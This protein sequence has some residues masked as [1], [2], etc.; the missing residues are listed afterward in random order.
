[1]KNFASALENVMPDAAAS[2]NGWTGSRASPA[3]ALL[4]HLQLC[5]ALLGRRGAFAAFFCAPLT[6][7]RKSPDAIASG[8]FY[9]KRGRHFRVPFQS[10]VNGKFR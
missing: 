10:P 1:M 8:S 9:D 5:G 7:S 2:P 6:L 3:I 4:K